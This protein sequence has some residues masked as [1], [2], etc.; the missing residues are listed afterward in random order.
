MAANNTLVDRFVE[1][2]PRRPEDARLRGYGVS[3]WT[4][5]GYLRVVGNDPQQVADDYE[6][7]LEA[8]HAAIE[9]Y[10]SNRVLIDARP[11]MNAA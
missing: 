11:A 3:V 5:I 10:H 6:I 2:D 4:L 7:P 1:P 8:V 9:F